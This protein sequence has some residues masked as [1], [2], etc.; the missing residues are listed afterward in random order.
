M[1]SFTEIIVN[2]KT[3]SILDMKTFLESMSLKRRRVRN[4]MK[5]LASLK[6]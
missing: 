6:E 2:K 3:T 4:I 1:V 5:N